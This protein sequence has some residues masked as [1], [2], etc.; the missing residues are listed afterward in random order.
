MKL[1]L[2]FFA[3]AIVVG[4]AIAYFQYSRPVHVTGSGQ[5]YV[6]VDEVL[7]DH[8][9]SGLDD[10]RLY[11]AQR[12]IP[13]AQEIERGSSE[14]VQKDVRVLEPGTIGGK[15]QW[16]L[17]MEGQAEYDR[18]ELKIAAQN[19]VVK[20]EV[21]G[22]D[23]LHG[24]KWVSLNKTVLYDLSED[25]LGG[26]RTLRLPVT[27]YRY[28]RV[29]CEG[30]IKPQE[31]TG[32]SASV[33]REE[34]EVWR[35]VGGEPSRTQEG[36]DQVFTFVL[37]H[38]MPVERIEFTVDSA[39][40]NFLRTVDVQGNNDER[41]G[42]GEISRIHTVRHGQKIDVDDSSISVSSMITLVFSRKN[43]A[44]RRPKW[45]RS[46]KTPRIPE[47]PMNAHGP[48]STPWCCGSPLSWPWYC[49]V[50]SRS[51][52]CVR[53]RRSKHSALALS[54]QHSALSHGTSSRRR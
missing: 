31:I 3:L 49:W 39:P 41:L 27:T 7:W 35:S 14:T 53:R 18:V 20:A 22:Q 6:V 2:K 25:R 54:T 34:K 4:P 36:K 10:L 32:A 40:P 52:R 33:R 21:E 42:S 48:S 24:S 37:P 16:I 9:G 38:N 28:L 50:E 26:N 51:D 13:V 44:L 47:G 11:D 45:D 15:T 8:S 12:E 30:Q 19:F 5:H 23:D 29:T 46:G 17:D 1:A 43:P